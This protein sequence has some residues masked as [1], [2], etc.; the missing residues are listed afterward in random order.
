MILTS[1]HEVSPRR[2]RLWNGIRWM[3]PRRAR[4]FFEGCREIPGQLWYEERKLLYAT[5]RKHQP[6]VI[7]EVGTWKG[8]GSTQFISNALFANGTGH[9]HTIEA[10]SE[11]H[12]FAVNAYAQ[13]LPHLLP[14]ITFHQGYSTD[15]YPGLLREK[16][17]IDAVFLD[18]RDDP[19]LTLREFEMFSPHL[20]PGA[21]LMA[22]D[23]DNQKMEALRPLLEGA[24]DWK[25][26]RVLHPPR[27]VGFAV[28]RKTD[29][30]GMPK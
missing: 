23:W 3:V 25:L 8:G 2:Q 26:L 5:I 16:G 21:L 12:Q 7:F 13:H 17:K 6:R 27:S 9:L 20:G 15:L 1:F 11:F 22:H 29:P 24:G 28:L 14:H 30:P 4:W 18:G 19:E 10:D